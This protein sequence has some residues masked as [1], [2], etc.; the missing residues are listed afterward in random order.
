MKGNLKYLKHAMHDSFMKFGTLSYSYGTLGTLME[1]SLDPQKKIA[2]WMVSHAW[3]T[4]FA[5]TSGMLMQ[6]AL[7]RRFSAVDEKEAEQS[8]C[9]WCLGSSQMSPIGSMGLVYLPTCG[10]CR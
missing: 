6:H 3:S 4:N 2:E 10:K 5:A 7:S 9:Y 8:M 1:G